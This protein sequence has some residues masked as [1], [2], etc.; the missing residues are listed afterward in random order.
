MTTHS[1]T[2]L[3]RR[4]GRAGFKND[5]VRSAILPEW[6]DQQCV[7]N[8]AVLPD[9]EIR[10]ARFLGTP[11]ASVRN[12]DARLVAPTYE[13]AQLRRIRDLERDRLAAAIHAAI[14]IAGAVVR[15]IRERNSV[16]RVPPQDALAWRNEILHGGS[17]LKLPHILTDCW[18]RGIP[19][20]PIDVLPVPN[21]QGLACVVEGHPVVVLGHKH[22]EPGRV[23]FL[24]A[25][26]VGHIAAGDC[27][28]E[29]PVVD[30][31][32]E[33]VDNTDPEKRADRYATSL[34]VGTTRIPDLIATGPKDL[35][36]K[37]AKI[38]RE[39]AVDAG[40]VIWSWARKTGDYA[41]AVTAVKALYRATGARRV[42]REHFE[43]FVDL[44]SASETDRALLRSVAGGLAHDATTGRQ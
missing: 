15:N 16:P 27:D 18:N 21:F 44:G 8:V 34:L 22:D 30:E 37:A 38:E 33:V 26:E 28:A 36:S 19:V 7:R 20:V 10:V 2:S 12:P 32:E 14:Q 25:H 43:R 41:R 23:S 35:A 1:F 11:I 17:A 3:M 24:I 31:E 9:I 40:A 13:G 29:H 39:S 42:L 5:F 4:L 6:W